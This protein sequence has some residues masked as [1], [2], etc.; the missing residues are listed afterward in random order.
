MYEHGKNLPTNTEEA[1]NHYTA[2]SKQGLTDATVALGLL[3]LRSSTQQKTYTYLDAIDCILPAA[4]SGN[5]SAQA[6]VGYIYSFCGPVVHPELNQEIVKNFLQSASSSGNDLAKGI[7]LWLKGDL[8]NAIR[9]LESP[10]CFRDPLARSIS[11]KYLYQ[12]QKKLSKDKKAELNALADKGNPI[13]LSIRGELYLKEKEYQKALGTFQLLEEKG[14]KG[15]LLNLG[16]MYAGGYGVRQDD[17]KAREFFQRAETSPL[18]TDCI[19]YFKA[20]G[21]GGF[22]K[23][24]STDYKFVTDKKQLEK[25]LEGKGF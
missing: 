9:F 21:R 5:A 17:S 8:V 22:T 11:L 1:I 19:E 6:A 3:Y 2:A 20:K 16:L 12:L 23:V 4:R 18:A 25:I 7:Q 14:D 24:K 13:C 15:P 10:S